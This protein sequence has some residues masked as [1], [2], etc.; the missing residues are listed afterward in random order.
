MQLALA[1]GI[2]TTDHESASFKHPV[3]IIAGK[4]HH[5]G[6]LIGDGAGALAADEWIARA[7]SDGIDQGQRFTTAEYN[8]IA[9]FAGMP[10]A[11]YC[12]GE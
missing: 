6:D 4:V 7:Y 12:S 3:F 11:N 10:L 5:P 9:R 1:Q 8:L 2:L